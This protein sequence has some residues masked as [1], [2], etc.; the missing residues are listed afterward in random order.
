MRARRWCRPSPRGSTSTAARVEDVVV[1]DA[2]LDEAALVVTGRRERVVLDRRERE[3]RV[4]RPARIADADDPRVRVLLAGDV[5]VAA[6]LDHE[7][8]EA[9]VEQQLRA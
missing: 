2:A 3:H 4:T 8:R 9:L 7:A 6:G 1:A 5:H